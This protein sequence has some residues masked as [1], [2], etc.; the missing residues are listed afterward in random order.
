MQTCPICK[1][2]YEGMVCICCGYDRSRDCENH[3]T[4]G[5]VPP[6]ASVSRR[7]ALWKNTQG[8]LLHCPGCGG[9]AF[10][11]KISEGAAVCT[12]CG[13]VTKTPGLGQG[14]LRAPAVRTAEMPKA[15]ESQKPK[16]CQIAA[17]LDH[18]AALWT[19]GTV[20]AAGKNDDGQCDVSEWKDMVSIAV[21]GSSTVGLRA[22]GVILI[23]GPGRKYASLSVKNFAAIGTEYYLAGV[24]RDGK[25]QFMGPVDE[26]IKKAVSWWRDIVAVSS[27]Y[28]GTVGL[29]KNGTVVAA[30]EKRGN[31]AWKKAVSMW[32][33][34]TQIECG[35]YTVGLRKD[36]T[37][38]AVDNKGK[39]VSEVECWTDVRCI[40]SNAG[41]LAIRTDG[42]VLQYGFDW[43]PRNIYRDFRE[44]LPK[45]NNI[46]ELQA[47]SC[48]NRDFDT[49][50]M[51][52]VGLTEDGT[53]INTNSFALGVEWYA[54]DLMLRND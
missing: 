40:K 54:S 39:K 17:T 22:D 24:T 35:I 8:E 37:V 36:G 13:K 30:V 33:N 20:T 45:W 29:K 26:D 10:L 28:C 7:A 12:D 18:A 4:L 11:L 19:D 14:T 51:Y 42:T 1:S 46:I 21:N 43:M 52:V 16:I 6:L 53:I 32:R 31:A 3:P 49:N 44:D 9:S 15:A 23:A 38:V 41:I 48:R 5:A 47:V 25:V 34:I 50:T 27:G 2:E